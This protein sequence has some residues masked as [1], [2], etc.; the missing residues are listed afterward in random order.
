[1]RPQRHGSPPD[2]KA[3]L[4]ALSRVIERDEQGVFPARSSRTWRLLVSRILSW[5][6]QHWTEPGDRRMEVSCVALLQLGLRRSVMWPRLTSK[7]SQPK[8]K[9]S[10]FRGVTQ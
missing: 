1:M 10:D 7:D 8:K 9:A 3:I 2:R 6:G 4:L 5:L